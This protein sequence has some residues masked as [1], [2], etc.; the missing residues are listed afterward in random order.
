M[1]QPKDKDDIYKAF[2]RRHPDR[3]PPIQEGYTWDDLRAYERA[4]VRR[5]ADP[6]FEAECRTGDRCRL[7]MDEGR[8]ALFVW[9]ADATGWTSRVKP[10]GAD[11]SSMEGLLFGTFGR[12]GARPAIIT[13]RELTET[14]WENGLTMED[15]RMAFRGMPA[16]GVIARMEFARNLGDGDYYPVTCDTW[17]IAPTR[18]ATL[19]MDGSI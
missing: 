12:D 18:Q 2:N 10:C 19:S 17:V 6:A 7:M 13:R 14:L 3:Q 1:Q 11:R 16:P 9:F 15:F 5:R 8:D 4:C